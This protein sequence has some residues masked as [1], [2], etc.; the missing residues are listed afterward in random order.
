MK[1]LSVEARID[2]RRVDLVAFRPYID[3]YATVA[4]KSAEASAKGTVTV[5]GQGDA[6]RVAYSGAAS[7]TNV[8]SV[9]TKINENLVNWD[10]VGLTGVDFRWTKSDPLHL[11]VSAVEV[12]KAYARVVVTPEGKINLQLLKGETQDSPA[13]AA[14][15]TAEPPKPR[16]IRIDRIALVDSRLDFTDHFIKP[17]YSAD[18]R[19]LHGSVTNLSSDPASR[20]VVDLKGSYGEASP[21]AIAGT[22]N[23]L[24]GDL[25]LDITASAKDIGLPALSAYSERYAGYGITQG[26]LELGVKYHID[27]GTLEGRNK[28]VLDQLVFGE[29]V[30]SPEATKLPVL[31]AVN[32]LKDSKGVINVTLPISGSLSDPHFAIG[33]LIIQVVAGIFKKAVTSPFSLL[34]GGASGSGA[35]SG[36]DLAFVDFAPGRDDISPE[37]EKKLQ[38]LAKALLDRPAISLQLTPR[39]DDV[40]DLQALKQAA[41]LQKVKAAGGAAYAP[42]EY[43]RYLKLVFDREKIPKPE[44]KD[45]G[46]KELSVAQMEALLLE[47]IEIGPDALNALALRRSENVRNYLVQQAHLP[48]ERVH[49]AT[50]GPAS[51]EA[52]HASRVEFTLG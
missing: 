19:E 25:F 3:A 2:A 15:A 41:L 17:N 8:A 34:S 22:I 7:V 6:M 24:R 43:P 47:R 37:G 1:P 20:G 31:F 33:D 12:K 4:L 49:M 9:D 45:A 18:V 32:L 51:P 30:E 42:G 28:I 36:E 21:V 29:K 5:T 14:P 50:P 27:G 46:N 35:A 52:S 40:K 10:S 13:A 11:A 44:S 48:V 16:D 39:V 26:K 38:A 23:P